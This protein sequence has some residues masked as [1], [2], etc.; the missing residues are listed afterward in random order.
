MPP[1]Y[2]IQARTVTTH[3][4]TFTRHLTQYPVVELRVGYCTC[5][6]R[7][8]RHTKLAELAVAELQAKA[9][10]GATELVL[11][12]RAVLV[13]VEQPEGVL[14]LGKL[15]GKAIREVTVR[16]HGSDGSGDRLGSHS[17]CFASWGAAFL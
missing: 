11:G 13:L 8:I 4:H 15:V 9:S 17:R 5:A 6:V 16:L 14:H 10:K 12:H 2:T 1:T 7:V 3:A